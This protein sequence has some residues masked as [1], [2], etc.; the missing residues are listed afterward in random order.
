MGVVGN[1]L[2]QEGDVLLRDD[3]ATVLYW[4]GICGQFARI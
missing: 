2:A 4:T 3:P 1:E